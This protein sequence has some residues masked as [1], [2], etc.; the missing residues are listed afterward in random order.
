MNDIE[1]IARTRD[2][3][4]K[5]IAAS[6]GRIEN[7]TEV[8]IRDSLLERMATHGELFPQGW[9]DPPPGGSSVLWAQ[10]PFNRLQFETL[11]DKSFWP[12]EISRFETETVGMI[13]LSSVDRPTKMIGDIGLTIYNGADAKIQEHIRAVLGVIHG[14]AERAKVGMKL[15][16]LYAEAMR[17]FDTHHKVI[18]WMT[19]HDDPMK[20]NLGHTIPGS[21]GES[22]PDESTFEEIKE[23]IRSKRIYIN[24]SE[25]FRLPSTCAL[26]VEA[27]LVD[28]RDL[29]LSNVLFHLIVTFSEGERRILTNFDDIFRTVAMNYML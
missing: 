2:T 8:E 1:A 23:F 14:V 12:S 24:E 16:H 6:L 7:A 18:K 22:V 13:Y 26:T 3:T 4:S 20:V 27:R 15:S 21:F 25:T 28:T 9:Y 5:I 19:T 11:R 17:M 10:R 29:D